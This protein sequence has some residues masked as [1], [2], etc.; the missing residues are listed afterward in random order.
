MTLMTRQ[1]EKGVKAER[2]RIIALLTPPPYEKCRC[3]EWYSDCLF[4]RTT[5]REVIKVING[6]SDA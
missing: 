5:Y 6:E 2:E 4:C 1:Y 3:D